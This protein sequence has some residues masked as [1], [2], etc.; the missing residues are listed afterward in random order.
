MT[1]DLLFVS[2]RVDVVPGQHLR[3]G[4]ADPA[5]DLNS[6]PVLSGAGLRV[7]GI[8]AASGPVDLRPREQGQNFSLLTQLCSTVV[9]KE[10]PTLVEG[11][12]DSGGDFF[13]LPELRYWNSWHHGQVLTPRQS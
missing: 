6:M 2:L 1:G 8:D 10:R 11:I 12:P 7:P 5:L 13:A 3:F 4:E 9:G